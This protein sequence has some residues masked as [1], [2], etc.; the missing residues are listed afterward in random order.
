MRKP[1]VL[2][3]HA[4][5]EALQEALAKSLQWARTGGQSDTLL[6]NSLRSSKFCSEV[7]GHLND[8]VQA[9]VPTVNLKRRQIQVLGTGPRKAGEW[10]LDIVWSD[11]ARPDPRMRVDAP[12][13]PTKIWCALECESKTG[14]REFFMDFAKLLNVRSQI[15]I[16][17]GGL[18][19]RQED[20]ARGYMRLRLEQSLKLISD[21]EDRAAW[22]IGFWPSPRGAG[23]S[24]LWNGIEKHPHLNKVTLFCLGENGFSEV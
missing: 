19:Q 10:L 21:S 2:E 5:Q 12:G 13:V 3:P 14:S 11:E 24:S 7:G 6:S 20:K 4:L 15:K 23:G 18:N 9:S 17:L 1:A 16:F 22:Y 8:L